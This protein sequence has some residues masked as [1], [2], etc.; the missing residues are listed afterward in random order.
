MLEPRP[1]MTSA[2]P[3][4]IAL[5]VEYRWKTRTGSSEL[6]TVTAEPSRMRSVRAAIAASTTSAADNGMSSVWCSPMPKKSMPAASAATPC[7]TRS[8]IVCAC[9]SGC[10]AASQVTSPNV[11]SPNSR[12]KSRSA[13]VG[14]AVFICGPFW[15]G[16]IRLVRGWVRRPHPGIRRRRIRLRSAGRRRRVRPVRRRRRR[17]GCRP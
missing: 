4:E 8:R 14:A 1:R 3:S 10:P 13:G 2:R 17:A 9:E 16:W 11:S 15:S 6:S 12:G 7:S 5:S